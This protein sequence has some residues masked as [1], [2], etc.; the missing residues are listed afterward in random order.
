MMKED[1]YFQI[2]GRSQENGWSWPPI[3]SGMIT[4]AD[5]N[6]ARKIIEQDYGGLKFKMGGNHAEPF[7][8]SIMSMKDKPYLRDRF[9]DRSCKQCNS[10][11]TLNEKYIVDAGGSRE[12]CCGDCHRQWREDNGQA[13]VRDNNFDFNGIHEPVIYKITCK[14]DGLCYIGKTTQAFTLRWYQHFYHG[15]STKFHEAIKKSGKSGWAF[16]VIEVIDIPDSVTGLEKS[17]LI[18][19]R[20]SYWIKYYNSIANG[21]NSVISQSDDDLHENTQISIDLL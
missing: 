5:R 16:E 10:T 14:N 12:F 9:I 15:G 4:C 13:Y 1:F 20:E 7:L 6:E 11:Y 2:K 17:R 3:H 21:Y 18:L 8:L 19:A